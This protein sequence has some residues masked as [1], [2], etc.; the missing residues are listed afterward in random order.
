MKDRGEGFFRTSFGF[1]EFHALFEA[2]NAFCE[3]G[4]RLEGC[5]QTLWRTK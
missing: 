2:D 5:S 3:S 4:V 1:I